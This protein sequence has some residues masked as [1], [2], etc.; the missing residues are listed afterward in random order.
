MPWK[1]IVCTYHV[2][3]AFQNESALYGC[4]KIKQ[5]LAQNKRLIWSLSDCN[6]TR[7]HNH[8]VRKRTLDHLTIKTSKSKYLMKFNWCPLIAE[9]N[10][11]L[12]YF[13][14]SMSKSL[15]TSRILLA[16]SFR[17]HSL[18]WR[19]RTQELTPKTQETECKIGAKNPVS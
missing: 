2:T 7:I 15:I 18:T 3:Y 6:A 12:V 11:R 10:C 5:L 17:R 19:T 14:A 16:S 1:L 13:I 4:G 9:M 8:L